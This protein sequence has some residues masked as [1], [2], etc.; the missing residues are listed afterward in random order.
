MP[1]W[2]QAG[3][4]SRLMM[5]VLHDDGTREYAY[6]PAGGLPATG[7]GSFPDELMAEANRNG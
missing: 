2:T 6:G 4:G 1:E 5:I 3:E 7:V